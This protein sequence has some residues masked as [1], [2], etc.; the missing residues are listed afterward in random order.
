MM[1][2]T[3]ESQSFKVGEKVG[4]YQQQTFYFT[5]EEINCLT[6]FLLLLS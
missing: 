3:T 2:E 5:D 6:R 4:D 1:T